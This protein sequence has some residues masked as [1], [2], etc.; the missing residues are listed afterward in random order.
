MASLLLTRRSNYNEVHDTQTVDTPDNEDHTFCGIQFDV[1][2]RKLVPLEFVTISSVWVRGDLGPMTVWSSPGG[3]ASK[4][5]DKDAWRLHYSKCHEPSRKA[6]AELV[7][8]TPVTLAPGGRVGL[9]IH[10]ALPNDRAN[11]SFSVQK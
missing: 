6:F 11:F 9:Y 4:E 8:E 7:L 3:F 10:S 1:V 2:C 5:E